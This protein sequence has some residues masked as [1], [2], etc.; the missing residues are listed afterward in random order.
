MT[1]LI[2]LRK[3]VQTDFS[4]SPPPCVNEIPCSDIIKKRDVTKNLL[5]GLAL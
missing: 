3:V 2:P 1:G 4:T 5:T